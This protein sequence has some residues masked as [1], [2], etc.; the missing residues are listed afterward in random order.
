MIYSRYN[1]KPTFVFIQEAQTKHGNFY[2]Y[3]VTEY[4]NYSTFVNIG[5]PKHGIFKIRPD[6][7]L[8]GAKCPECRHSDQRELRSLGTEQFVS[9]AIAI[10]GYEYH[11]DKVQYVNARTKVIIGCPKHGD[12]EQQPRA[13]LYQK[14]KCPRCS[15]SG[16]SKVEQAWLDSI[17]LPCDSTHRRVRLDLGT[18]SMIV[19]G[20]DPETNT[21]YEFHG[22]FWHGNPKVYSSVDFNQM[23]KCSFG[24][25]YQRTKDIEKLIMSAGFNLVVCWESEFQHTTK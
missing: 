17:G 15:K 4:K 23:T 5:C 11:Y 14:T 20:F 24:D 25:L 12:F 7:H 19:D 9:S 13:H 8:K 6:H 18:R 1:P 2:D 10:H 22:D 3:S 16:S 21:V